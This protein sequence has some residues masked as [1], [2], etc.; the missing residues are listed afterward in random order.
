MGGTII[1]P[2]LARRAEERLARGEA[3]DV[4]K[5]VLMASPV[6][7]DDGLSGHGSMREVIRG[8]TIRSSWKRCIN[9]LTSR[10]ACRSRNERDPAGVQY[11]VSLGFYGRACHLA[12]IHDSAHFLYG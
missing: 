1:L 6:V 5:V 3:M 8:V 12:A 11:T 10:P 9:R 7:F 2:Y 4:R